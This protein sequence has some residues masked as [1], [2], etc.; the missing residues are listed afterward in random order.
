MWPCA[1]AHACACACACAP[2]IGAIGCSLLR[3]AGV[4]YMFTVGLR[5][6]LRRIKRASRLEVFLGTQRGITPNRRG[7]HVRQAGQ[8]SCWRRAV[9]KKTNEE[10]VIAHSLR[11]SPWPG[12][13]CMSCIERLGV[14][15]LFFALPHERSGP[16]ER[17]IK[18]AHLGQRRTF[19]GS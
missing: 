13:R 15:F 5:L 6:A 17:R 4:L 3:H 9:R 12:S 16:A 1:C 11:T 19:A 8:D 14:F 18:R 2:A 10:R 7:R